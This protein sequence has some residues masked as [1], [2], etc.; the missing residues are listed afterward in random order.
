M[1]AEAARWRPGP[2]RHNIW[3]LALHIAYWEYAV[4]RR[5]EDLPSG[6]FPRAPSDWPAIPEAAT[7][8]AWKADRA[9]LRAEHDALAD[10]IARFAP[11]RLDDPAPG[12]KSYRCIDLMHGVVMHNTYHTG[13]IQLIKRRIAGNPQD[14]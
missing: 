4:R 13:Q 1:N 3:E 2:K 10:A 9:L 6:S 8:I 12:S 11:A 7:E 5:L 14:E